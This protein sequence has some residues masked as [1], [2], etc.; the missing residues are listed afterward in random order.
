MQCDDVIA[1]EG[2]YSGG[3]G[4]GDGDGDLH[5]FPQLHVGGDVL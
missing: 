2:G 1:G 3:G 5:S 4:D